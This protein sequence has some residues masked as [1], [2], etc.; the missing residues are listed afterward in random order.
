MF[1]NFVSDR[2]YIIAEIGGNFN[3]FEEAKRLVDI[4]AE[5]KVDAVKLQTYRAE[6]HVSKTAMFDME[7][8]GKVPQFELLQQLEVSEDFHRSIFDYVNNSGLDWF[9]TPSHITD[10]QILEKLNVGAYKLGSDDA[11]NLPFLKEIAEIGKPMIV[12]TGM[13]TM[14]EVDSAV[15]AILSTG[16]SRLSLLHAITNY[17]THPKSVNLNAITSM[18]KRYPQ[19]AIGY[20]DHTQNNYACLAAVALGSKILEKHV[21]YDKNA[22]GPDHL[23]SADR[24]ELMDLVAGVRQIESMLGNGIK[25]PSET[26][27]VSRINNRKS[28]VLTRNVKQ[29][30][31]L[32]KK[33][34]EI[35]RPAT[36]IEPKFIDILVGKEVNRD[37]LSDDSINWSDLK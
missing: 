27:R 2:T 3:T 5:C 30:E 35:K 13:C 1:R 36:G 17:P 15:E 10:V 14:S 18:Q 28:V 21:T 34:L 12:S 25:M 7:N 11:T 4:A 16:N 9:S 33:D 8:V 29:G 37:M 23:V 19:I 26:E 31:R 24:N 20:S 22:D 32:T 6:T